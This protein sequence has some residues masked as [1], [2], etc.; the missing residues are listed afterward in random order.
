MTQSSD[1]AVRWSDILDA[2][3]CSFRMCP[4][5]VLQAFRSQFFAHAVNVQAQ[6]AGPQ[7][8]SGFCLLCL[9]RCAGVEYFIDPLPYNDAYSII[10]RNDSV[11]GTYI[12][13]RAYNRGIYTAEGLLDSS[14]ADT[15][16]VQTGKPIAVKSRTSRT[17]ASITNPTTPCARQLSA[18]SSPNMPSVH[19][20]TK[21]A[22][23]GM[24]HARGDDRAYTA[25]RNR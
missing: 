9:P 23:A 16:L 2:T 14:W 21:T 5:D 13:A 24:K 20:T 17:P 15:A 8:L 3:H 7:S 11:S 6:L 4:I 22:S 1:N 19:G 12:R 10:V 18:K 25:P